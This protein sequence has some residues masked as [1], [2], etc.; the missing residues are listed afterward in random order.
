MPVVP[1]TILIQVDSSADTNSICGRI[2]IDLVKMN[3]YKDVEDV[4]SGRRISCDLRKNLPLNETVQIA[5]V[6]FPSSSK[7]EQP[8]R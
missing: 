3:A 6:D 5:V 1:D 2:P 8:P 4:A 7:I